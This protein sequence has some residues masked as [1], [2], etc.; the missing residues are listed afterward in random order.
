MN[1]LLSASGNF[2]PGNRKAISYIVV[3]YTGNKGDTAKNNATYFH[4]TPDLK[5]GA[6]Y[7]VDE[8]E[9]W[10]SVRDR[11][12]AYHCGTQSGY[13]H[14]V[15]RNANSIGVEICMWDKQGD[16]R[17]GSIDN[18]VL[19]VRDLMEKYYID[20]E[21]VVRHYD[22][23]GK[24]CPAPM[25][26]DESLWSE[27][28]AA[29]TAAEEETEVVRY[30]KLSDIPES[31]NFRAIIDQ[32]MTAGIIAGDGSDPDGNDDVIDLSHD[33]VR[34]L[35]FDYRAGVYDAAL[36]AAGIDPEEYK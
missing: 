13:K 6:H 14:P 24:K 29:L 33:M 35:I 4:N 30:N 17:Q 16:V 10:R 22:V 27:F 5:K 31:N 28:K 8:N 11:D 19:L 7:F 34:M 9:V 2:N 18:A 3:H 25:V 36:E 21:H 23:T 26:D 20:V 12:I 1:E 15:C 32:L